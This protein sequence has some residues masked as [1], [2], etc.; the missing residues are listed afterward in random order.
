MTDEEKEAE[1][2]SKEKSCHFREDF[3]NE[4]SQT[5]DKTSVSSDPLNTGKLYVPTELIIRY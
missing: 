1:L 3:I 5:Q 4:K 2:K